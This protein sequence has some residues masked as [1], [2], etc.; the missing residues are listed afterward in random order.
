MKDILT[1]L[2]DKRIKKLYEDNDIQQKK[3]MNLG[4]QTDKHKQT[5]KQ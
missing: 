2:P 4:R 5:N 3:Q 1:V